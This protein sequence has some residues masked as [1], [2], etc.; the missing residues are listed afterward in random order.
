[1]SFPIVFAL[2]NRFRFV[3]WFANP[4]AHQQCDLASLAANE[5]NQI[6]APKHTF[7]HPYSS[8]LIL[9]GLF[10]SESEYYVVVSLVVGTLSNVN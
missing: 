4:K 8:L 1:V 6:P 9:L 7:V 5:I 2:L 10:Q 3:V